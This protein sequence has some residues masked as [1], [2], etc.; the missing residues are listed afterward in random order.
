MEVKERPELTFL[1]RSR[2][3]QL[4]KESQKVKKSILIHTATAILT[5]PA[6]RTLFPI[7]KHR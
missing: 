2:K 4:L 3:M 6:A 7:I 1:L 5:P